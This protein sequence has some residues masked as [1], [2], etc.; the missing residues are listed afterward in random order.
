MAVAG[1]SSSKRFWKNS[2]QV[3]RN[4]AASK[5]GNGIISLLW[6]LR[7]HCNPDHNK[8]SSL[9]NTTVVLIF[10]NVGGIDPEKLYRATLR[11]LK[12]YWRGCFVITE[13]MRDCRYWELVK[14]IVYKL[15]SSSLLLAA[16]LIL[17]L[18]RDWT[19]F[20]A[21]SNVIEIFPFCRRHSVAG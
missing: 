15:P 10:P 7:C 16:S 4:T 14:V 12:I 1:K 9:R 8:V 19:N 20:R 17:W 3:P 6:Q 18:W 2:S 13:R 21:D 5:I 11:D